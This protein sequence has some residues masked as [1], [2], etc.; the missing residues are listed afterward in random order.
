MARRTELKPLQAGAARHRRTAL[1]PLQAG[2]ARQRVAR[3]D[4]VELRVRWRHHKC[5]LMNC[6]RPPQ[7]VGYPHDRHA[8]VCDVLRRF[9]RWD[10]RGARHLPDARVACPPHRRRRTCGH[11]TI[12]CYTILYAERAVTTLYYAIL[13]YTPNVRSRPHCICSISLIASLRS[14]VI[15]LRPPGVRAQPIWCQP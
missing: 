15:A 2:V 13:Y 3:E 6:V 5:V 9:G 4:V 12:L 8:A 1:K 14:A 7:V 10:R 11:Y